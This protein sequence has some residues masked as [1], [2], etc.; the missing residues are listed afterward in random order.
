MNQ[1]T[2][3]LLVLLLVT[4]SCLTLSSSVKAI[5]RTITVP[6]ETRTTSS[7]AKQ[8]PNTT[9]TPNSSQPLQPTSQQGTQQPQ[10]TPTVKPSPFPSAFVIA[11]SIVAL[12]AVFGAILSLCLRKRNRRETPTQ[13]S[14]SSYGDRF[15]S[16]G[17]CSRCGFA[18]LF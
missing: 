12:V 14:N 7:P 13:F 15:W 5:S 10:P 9:P 4:A 8:T 16:I 6:E 1:S 18:D 3:L 2:T 11:A 17:Y